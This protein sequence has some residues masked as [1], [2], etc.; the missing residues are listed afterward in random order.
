V[1][2]SNTCSKADI[3]SSQFAYAEENDKGV[4]IAWQLFLLTIGSTVGAIVVF[5]LTFHDTSLSGV[6]VSV[7][8]AFIVIMASATLVR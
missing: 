7:Y 1:L 2:L 4:Y 8:I 3:Q 5:G 6:P